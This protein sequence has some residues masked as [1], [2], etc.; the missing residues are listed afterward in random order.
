MV[1]S[2]KLHAQLL[3]SSSRTIAYRDFEKLMLA[4]GFEFD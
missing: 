4:F 3:Q 2:S 1:K